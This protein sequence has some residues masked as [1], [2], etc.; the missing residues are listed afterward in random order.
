MLRDPQGHWRALRP[1]ERSC[2]ESAGLFESR[3]GKQRYTAEADG[4]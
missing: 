4:D 3:N 1:A 2:A